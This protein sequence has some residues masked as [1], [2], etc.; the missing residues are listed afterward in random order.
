MKRLGW[1]VLLAAA[2]P[3]PLAAQYF[4]RNKV[5][6]GRFDFRIIQTEH[7]DVYYY[8][9]EREAALD[10][11]RMAERSYAKLSRVFSHTF[12][13]RKPIIVYASQSDFQQTNTSGGEEIDESTGGFTDYIRHR[14]IFP[15]TGAYE[16]NQ[17]VL[18][19]E[20]VHQFQ[21]DIWSRGRVG[22][23]GGTGTAAG[24]IQGILAANAPLWFGEGTAEYFS[25]G[26]VDPNTAMWLRDAANEGKL[27]DAEDFYRWFP[28]RFGHALIGYIGQRWGDEAIAQITKRGASGGIENALARVLGL[29]FPQLVQQWRDA[30]QK[31]YLPEVATHQKARAVAQVLLSEKKT[32]GGWHLAPALSPDGS[33]IVYLSERNFYFVDLWLADA[34]T[35]KTEKRLLKSTYSGN[36]ETFRFINSSESWSPDGRHLAVAAKHAGKDDIVII[37]TEKNRTVRSIRLP[38]SA[39]T[40]PAWSPDGTRLVFSG[41]QGGLSDLYLV[42]A[43]GSGLTRLTNDREADLHP[44][45]SPDGKTIAFATDRGPETDLTRLKWGSLRIALYHLDTGRIDL[46]EGLEVGRNSNPQWAPDGKSLAFVSD[47]N[48]V[49]NIYLYDLPDGQVYQLTD[50]YT[51]VQGI[52]PLSPVLSWAHAAD[53]LAFV[54]FEQGRYDVYTLDHPRALKKQPWPRGAVAARTLAAVAPAVPEIRRP[55][56]PPPQGPQILGGRAVYRTPQGFRLADSLPPDTTSAQP[57]VSVARILDSTEYALPDTTEFTFRPYKPKLEPEYVSRPTI[58][59]T[60]NNFG[61]GV[62][63][64]TGIVLGDMLGNH[65]LLIATSLNGRLNETYFQTQY[66]NLTRRLN[67]G[68]GATQLPFFY[69]AGASLAESP[70]AG[71]RLYR[72]DVVRLVMRQASVLGYYPLSRFRR[73]EFGVAGVNVTEDLRSFVIPFDPVTGAQ[74]RDAYVETT[75]LDG[76]SFLQPN[77]ALVFDNSLFGGVGPIIGR[78]SRFEIAPRVGQWRFT[79]INADYR[80]YDRIGGPFTLATRVQYYGQHGRDETKFRFFAG[81]PDY[82]RGYTYGSFFRNECTDPQFIGG[83]NSATGCGPVDQLVG[84]RLGIAGAEVRWPFFFGARVLTGFFPA[85]EGVAFFDAGVMFESGSTLKLHR[86]PGDDFSAVRT[87]LTSTGVGVRVNV[88]NFLIVRADYAF[89]LDRPGFTAGKSFFHKG[90]WTLSLGPTF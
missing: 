45:W 30:V 71:E 14:N 78:R 52:T 31:Q 59:Y 53:R 90:Y 68:V 57:I 9:A 87:P 10:V 8:P 4:G 46:P 80:R 16:E 7:F 36:Y 65:Q 54:Y 56:A 63:G 82:L 27:P 81:L 83:Q 49:A 24:G 85:V 22:P 2:L 18:Q 41:L 47:R 74:T 73:L 11:A 86:D 77:V 61:Q 29:S 60:R 66:A 3:V 1:A 50:F 72:E 48:G 37:D 43:D 13:E 25:L 23:G 84:T 20:M 42:N 38:L 67:W 12:E 51:G 21:F 55:T 32:G 89:P 34:R 28:Y 70:V 19:H 15:L 58:G 39:V 75:R 33:K 6:Y 88:L 44:V 26:P 40:T 76:A 69:F 64:S 79:T 17:H 5:Q 35:G 62:S